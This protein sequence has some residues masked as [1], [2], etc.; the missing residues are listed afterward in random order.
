[1]KRVAGIDVSKERLDAAFGDSD[2]GFE[3]MSFAND[4]AG[5]ELL[6]GHLT[7]GEATLVVLEATGGYEAAVAAELSTAG[8]AVAVVNPRQVRQFAQATGQ[9]AKTDRIDARVIALFGERVRPEVRP[10]SS[11]AEEEL[12]ALVSRRRQLVEMLTAE[13]NRLAR[14]RR[15]VRKDLEAHVRF[16]RARIKDVERDL[17]EAVE[18]SPLWRAND[19]LLRTVPGIGPTL[20]ALLLAELPEL[21]RLSPKQICALVGV[22]PFCRDSG[23][24]RGKRSIWGGRA[25]VRAALYMG[26]LVAARC[27]PLIRS[28]YQRLLSRGKPKKVALTACMRKLLVMLNAMIRDQRRWDPQSVTALA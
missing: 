25:S 14:A 12:Q 1:M 21:G 2:S 28:F 27:N 19:A 6:V 15:A 11:E 20:S 8:L 16:L 17:R 26:A 7:A 23:T 4:A 18:E 3:S 5:I 10:L 9:L 13:Q 22:A 24:L